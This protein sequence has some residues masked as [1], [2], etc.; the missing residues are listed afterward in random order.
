ME[1]A[2][3]SF[4]SKKEFAGYLKSFVEDLAADSLVVQE[5]QVFVP[6]SGEFGFDVKYSEEPGEAK[7]G[8]KLVWA[9]NLVVEDDE[10]EEIQ[11]EGVLEVEGAEEEAEKLQ[12]GYRQLLTKSQCVEH[13]KALIKDL[14]NDKLVVDQKTVIIPSGGDIVYKLKYAEETGSSKLS[15]KAK[16]SHYV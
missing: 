4:A 1:W 13:L 10:E 14:K 12:W 16:W 5:K 2:V 15:V 9:N 3:K 8:I 11:E 7:F 6:T